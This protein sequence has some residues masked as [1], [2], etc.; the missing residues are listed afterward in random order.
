MSRLKFDTKRARFIYLA[1]KRTNSIINQ[2][3]ILSHCNNKALY[4]YEDT[5]IDKIFV[6]IEDA[7]SEAKTKFKG[8]KREP[9]KLQP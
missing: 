7:L 2:I 3:R 4:E 9:F 6:A 8:K 5:E 1:Q